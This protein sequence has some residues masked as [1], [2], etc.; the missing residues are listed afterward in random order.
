MRSASPETRRPLGS[1][2][3]PGALLSALLVTVFAGLGLASF[4]GAGELDDFEIRTNRSLGGILDIAV[5]R[6]V[7]SLEDCAKKC[8][9]HSGHLN[10]VS[11]LWNEAERICRL[12]QS[13]GFGKEVSGTHSG[14]S[15][16]GRSYVWM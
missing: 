7:S 2:R 6:A 9:R 16:P 5:H 14:V 11:F 8:V 3:H 1:T 15:R 13:T 4:A 12:R 10:C